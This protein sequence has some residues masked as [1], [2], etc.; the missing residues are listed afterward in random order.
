[1]G[2]KPEE[3]KELQ[4]DIEVEL[5]QST[6]GT[7]VEDIIAESEATAEL[8]DSNKKHCTTDPRDLEIILLKARLEQTEKAMERIFAQIGANTYQ[9]RIFS[10]EV[11]TVRIKDEVLS[12][13]IVCED[14]NTAVSSFGS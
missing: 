5:N 13:N 12:K 14:L 7:T 1:M 2:D 6:S 11:E 10:K 8:K 4:K 9:P 3:D